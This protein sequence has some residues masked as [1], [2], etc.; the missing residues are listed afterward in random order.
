MKREIF[1]FLILVAALTLLSAGPTTARSAGHYAISWWTAD[2]G[3]CSSRGGGYSLSGTFGQPDVGSMSG[4][5]YL[6]AGGF[7]GD[8]G[9]AYSIFLPL[10]LRNS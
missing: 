7:W 2:C 8:A 5:G 1:P 9:A 6:L 4:D 3:S 10:V